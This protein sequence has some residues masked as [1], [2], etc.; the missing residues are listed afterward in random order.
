[1][2]RPVNLCRPEVRLVPLGAPAAAPDRISPRG[3]IARRFVRTILLLSG[4]LVLLLP[5]ATRLIGFGRRAR[6]LWLVH[7]ASAFFF[8]V[9]AEAYVGGWLTREATPQ[10]RQVITKGFDILWWLIPAIL[11]ISALERFIWLPLERKTG[12]NIPSLVRR[13]AAVVIL[14]FASFGIVAFVFEQKLTSLLA[15]S[16]LVAAII[17]LALQVNLANIFSGIAVNLERPFRIGDWIMVHG[18]NPNPETNIIGCVEDINWRT[19]RLRTTENTMVV[20]PNAVISEKTVTNFMF[21]GE[22]SRF[23]LEFIIDFSVPHETAIQ[24]LLE[25][26][27][28]V[29][30]DKGQGIMAD[31]PPK[32]RVTRTSEIGVHYKVRYWVVPRHTGPAKAR[33][34]VNAS[35]LT[36]LHEAGITP[37]S[38][39]PEFFRGSGQGG[40]EGSSP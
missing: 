39:R 23:E 30:D 17:G 7:T 35:V 14:L 25:A 40:A 5:L 37:V 31:P 34:L 1:M 15:T 19:T 20:V 21:P 16:G 11:V 10:I 3:T 4:A 33:H 8:L 13:A 2:F 18:R 26:V 22:R 32:V 24:V 36:H 12:Q 29:I 28:A 6:T 27:Q 9:A 38:L